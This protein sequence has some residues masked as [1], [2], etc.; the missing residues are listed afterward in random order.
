M[1]LTVTAA[2][3]ALLFSTAANAQTVVSPVNPDTPKPD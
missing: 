3:V 1:K 2:A